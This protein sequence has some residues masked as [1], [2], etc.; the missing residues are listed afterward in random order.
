MKSQIR[1]NEDEIKKG[2]FLKADTKMS[3]EEL[4]HLLVD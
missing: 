1:K 4:Y 3:D 2:K